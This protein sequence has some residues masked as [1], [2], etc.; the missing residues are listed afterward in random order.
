MTFKYSIPFREKIRGEN[1]AGENIRRVQ[2]KS[3]GKLVTFPRLNFGIV[4]LYSQKS[5][6]KNGFIASGIMEAA[7]N[8][9]AVIGKVEKPFKSSRTF[10]LYLAFCNCTVVK[11]FVLFTLF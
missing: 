9:Q 6:I 5:M 2:K 3:G 7:E 11:G 8:A 1:W 10:T 4:E